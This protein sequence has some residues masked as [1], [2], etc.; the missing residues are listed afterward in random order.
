ML[1]HNIQLLATKLPQA[2]ID[3]SGIFR[4]KT[5]ERERRFHFNNG[6]LPDSKASVTGAFILPYI[7]EVYA[8]QILK[9][10]LN[11]KR[12]VIAV[13]ASESVFLSKHTAVPLCK[14]K[15]YLTWTLLP[16]GNTRYLIP[17]SLPDLTNE[18]FVNVIDAANP[19]KRRTK[20]P[21]RIKWRRWLINMAVRKFRAPS[22]GVNPNDRMNLSARDRCLF[23]RTNANELH[24]S[25]SKSNG[26]PL[27]F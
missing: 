4:A 11:G 6:P 8:S 14:I 10:K 26:T 15:V 25:V 2:R 3:L 17:T 7:F 22:N 16:C 12:V 9:R 21:S 1:C 20:T 27:L 24:P 5:R 18:S 13:F 23:L 19:P